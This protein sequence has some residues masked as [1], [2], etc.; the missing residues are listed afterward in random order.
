[1]ETLNPEQLA[2]EGQAEYKKGEYLSA[3]LLFI[4]AAEGFTNVGDKL[5]AAEMANNSSVAYLKSGDAKSALESSIG[6]DLLFASKG[7]IKRQAMALGN[8]AAA[9]ENLKRYDEAIIAYEKSAQ[10]LNDAGEFELRAYVC[11]SLSSLQLHRGRYLEAYGTMRAG[12]MGVKAPNLR[13]K[14]LKSLMDLPFKF[15]K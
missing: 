12:V 9:L 6:T 15:L 1:M 11:Q 5:S 8:Q 2:A 13:Q 10:L 14:I 4:A 7:D 3:A